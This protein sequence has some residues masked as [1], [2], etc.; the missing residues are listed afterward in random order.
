MV[1]IYKQP[2]PGQ[3]NIILSLL[4]IFI[5]LFVEKKELLRCPLLPH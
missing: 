1:I 3:L 4:T 2:L 5:Y